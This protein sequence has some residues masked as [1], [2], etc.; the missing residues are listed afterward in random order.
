MG[1]QLINDQVVNVPDNMSINSGYSSEIQQM[2]A[3]N[4]FGSNKYQSSPMQYLAGFS[5]PSP[6]F[7]TAP[8]G[9]NNW[10]SLNPNYLARP[11]YTRMIASATK[12]P[13]TI[14]NTY[15]NR[16]G[17]A[18]NQDG[19][20]YTV[21]LRNS[22][23]MVNTLAK[24]P[25]ENPELIKQFMDGMNTYAKPLE[26]IGTGLQGIGNFYNAYQTNKLAKDQFAF[27]K[28]FAYKNMANQTKMINT[29][30]SDRANARAAS[31]GMQGDARQ[32]YTDDYMK[33]HGL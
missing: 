5:T 31:Y 9:P 27:T 22:G 10:S 2:L 15:G 8:L 25:T 29:Q 11:D 23:E 16:I 4:G 13:S 19:G 33:K 24:N 26:L 32:R 12:L 6:T 17:N 20:E 28:D 1:L 21:N 14:P 3:N 7:A 18:F 30:L